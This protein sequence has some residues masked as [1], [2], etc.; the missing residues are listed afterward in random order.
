MA[1]Q[2]VPEYD[3]LKKV[4]GSP[5]FEC[6][7]KATATWLLAFWL[8]HVGLMYLQ[9]LWKSVFPKPIRADKSRQA[10]KMDTFT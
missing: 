5:V 1:H 4:L 10:L 3:V 9:L 2:H 7:E 6:A 8:C